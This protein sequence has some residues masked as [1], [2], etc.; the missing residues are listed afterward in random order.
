MIKIYDTMLAGS[1][2]S[3]FSLFRAGNLIF[4]LLV[5]LPAYLYHLSR[6]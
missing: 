4:G 1:L 3:V 6:K 2:V 5:L